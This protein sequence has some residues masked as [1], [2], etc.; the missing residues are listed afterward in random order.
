MPK[1]IQFR[2]TGGPEALEF[3]DL[4]VAAPGAGQV[5]IRH[6]AIG[7]NFIDIYQRTG[8][9]PV[10][11]PAIAG[12]EG[13]GVVESVGPDVH[14]LQPGDR[15][16]YTIVPGS[17]CE[18]R[19]I[20]ADRL[21]KLPEDISDTQAAG[22][23]LK[24][25]TVHYLIFSTYP[26]KRGEWVLWHAAAGGV[27]LI[28]VQW[29][30]A[31]GVTTIGTAGSDE[32]CALAQR[33]GATHTVN[34]TRE[35]FVERVGA[36]TAGKKLPVVYDSVG[37][38]TWEGSLDCLKPRGMMVSFGNASGPVPP[39]QLGILATKGSLYVTRP[40]LGTYIAT[41]EELQHRAQA[42]FDI[43]RQGQV[44]VEVGRTYPLAEAAQAHRDLESR[45]TTGSIVLIP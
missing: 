17:Y 39:I 1:A 44:R 21:V 42:L 29:L 30:R 35:N 38:S 15:V 25:L 13:A 45:K 3:V 37:K 20:A 9:Y 16:A 14:D 41:R 33:H 18:V 11:L 19:L 12:Q 32:K 22:M 43:V 34:Y 6:T 36:L 40:T 27:G 7:V 5:R 4:P 23:M 28:A 10:P 26:V 24:G 8:L 31:L 2:K